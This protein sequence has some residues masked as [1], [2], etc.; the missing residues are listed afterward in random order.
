MMEESNVTLWKLPDAH[1][2]M[3]YSVYDNLAILFS[4]SL[5]YPGCCKQ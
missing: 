2:H 5:Q 4:K 1:K 3:I